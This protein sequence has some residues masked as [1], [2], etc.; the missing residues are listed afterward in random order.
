MQTIT[1]IGLASPRAISTPQSGRSESVLRHS[2]CGFPGVD[3]S[4]SVKGAVHNVEN[5]RLHSIVMARATFLA[6]N[7][8]A[9][10]ARLTSRPSVPDWP[11]RRGLR[12]RHAG[13]RG[14]SFIHTKPRIGSCEAAK[15][16]LGRTYFLESNWGPSFERKGRRW[17][18]PHT[19]TAGSTAQRTPSKN[20]AVGD[21]GKA[22]G[23]QPTALLFEFCA[24]PI[25]GRL[26]DQNRSRRNSIC[27][28]LQC[29]HTLRLIVCL[30]AAA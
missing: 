8:G 17:K 16:P 7:G 26:G 24:R 21:E 28:P 27:V 12:P 20:T 9:V 15:K 11:R 13:R 30:L 4:R 6:S 10:T 22:V 18:Q 29:G 14:L 3:L 2:G 5:S 19:F 25:A 23:V 1:T